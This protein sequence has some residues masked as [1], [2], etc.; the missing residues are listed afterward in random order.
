MADKLDAELLALA[1][2]DESSGEEGPASPN[3]RTPS[4]Q[5]PSSAQRLAPTTADMGRKGVAH[6]TKKGR[7]ARQ[8]SRREDS[9]DGELSSVSSEH[10]LQSAAMSESRSEASD[11]PAESG[12]NPYPYERLY[13]N[14]K[15]KEEIMAMPML[16][17]EEILAEREAAVERHNQDQALRRLLASREREEAKTAAKTKRKADAADLGESQRKSSRQRTARGGQKAGEVSSAMEAYK[18]HREEKRLGDEQRRK[19]ARD[20]P[21]DRDRSPNQDAYSDID[22]DG[23]SEVEWD[24]RKYN[25]R[26]STPPRDQS[27]AELVDI[28]RARVGRD[29]FAQVCFY[30][31]FEETLTDCYVRICIGPGKIPGVNEYRLCKIKGFEKGR[32]YA[33]AGPNGRMFA[34]DQYVRAAHGKAERNWPFL[35][36]SN[37]K[38]TEDEWR[39]YRATLANENIPL[40]FR[41]DINKKLGLIN[42]LISHH[43]TEPEISEKIARQNAV[44]DRINRAGLRSQLKDQIHQASLKGNVEE[45]ERLEDELRAIVPEKLAF[46]TS[47][48]RSETKDKDDQQDKLAE[49]NRRNERL[50]AERIRKAQLAEQKKRLARKVAPKP[51]DKL[52]KPSNDVD[53]L[54]GSDISRT[55]TPLNGTVSPNPSTPRSGTPL[56]TARPVP[57]DKKGFPML[58]KRMDDEEALAA[59]DLGIEIEI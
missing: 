59:M 39:R 45:V 30:P 32:P 25:R 19:E 24:D 58:R 35:E 46:N 31:R 43:F 53:D 6:S 4:P 22:A 16:Q 49:L 38:F 37:Q 20:R 34:T 18:R 40:P 26:A 9:E 17:R 13:V 8:R 21:K 36:C 29:N 33:M 56:G 11:S 7:V 50:N 15:E 51:D 41:A 44:L 5:M 57:R 14:E 47:L 3:G 28:Q 54:F 12:S 1:G 23:E 27:V 52:L 10:S 48:Q 55:G 42:N 2:G